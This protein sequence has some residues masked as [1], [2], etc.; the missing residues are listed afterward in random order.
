MATSTTMDVKTA[1]QQVEAATAAKKITPGAEQNIRVWLTES[2]YASYKD[3]VIEHIA[4]GK[5]KELD[6][7]FWT[8]IPFGTGGRRGKMYPI[9]S[10]AINDRTIG[11]S[12]QGLAA[13]VK[14]HYP[15]GTKLSCAIA[16]DTRHRSRHF[17]ELCSEIM[18]AAGFKVFFLD[19]YRSTPELS[20][21]VR[22]KQCHC[23]IMVTASHNPP[24][25][26][27]VKAYWS[28]GGQ[29]LPPHDQGVI[30]RVMS[31]DTIER[32]SFAEA[33][34]KGQVV[35]CQ[36]EL[37]E[38]Y[39]RN[40]LAQSM[41]GPRDLK[42]IYSP[43]HGVGAASVVPALAG[44]GF[45]DVEVFAPQ[46]EPNGDFPNVP[47]HVSNPENPATFDAMIE[48]AKVI[49]ADLILSTDPD[50]DRLGCAAPLTQGG[51]AWKTFTGNQIG[52]LLTDYL[53][54]SFKKAGRLSRENYIVKTLV[55]TEMARRIANSYGVKTLGDLLVGFKWIA[56]TIDDE[57]PEKFVF[58]T[59]ESHGFQAGTYTRDKDGT[60]AAM[61]LAE[62]AA[63]MKGQGKTLHE[64]LDSLFWQH[65]CH[66]ENTVSQTMPGSEGMANMMK[67]MAL[68]RSH[69]PASV[70]GMKVKQMRDYENLQILVAGKPP[71]PLVGPKGDLVIMDLEAEGNYVAVR[72]SGTEPK[73]KFYMFTY[74]PAE[75]LANL[76]TT[77]QELADRLKAMQKDLFALAE[78][79]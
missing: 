63:Q 10:N 70:A 17:A 38:V 54:E 7:V 76:E 44:A 77:K 6:D 56:M 24:S 1:I 58:G 19:G 42:I 32:A 65:G 43:M 22:H 71:Q 52:A 40:I 4:A 50:A 49:K 74:E 8:V 15:S 13:Y 66:L 78:K 20:L 23:G 46:A 72:P 61:L 26:N 3:Q 67:L 48:R 55:T 47:G 53:L 18:V 79:I 12:A 2:R 9:G 33:L 35:Y 75:M 31:T 73:V 64:K 57:G 45:K 37:D 69:P 68:L 39:Q 62:L 59:E 36:Q 5:W 21:T 11:E 28:T 27:A 29:L 14:D 16:Y 51:T 25:D 60:V 34:A 41:P 30:D